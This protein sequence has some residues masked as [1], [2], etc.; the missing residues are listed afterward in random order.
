MEACSLPFA[1]LIQNQYY[2]NATINNNNSLTLYAT[3]NIMGCG[4][5]LLFQD[6]YVSAYTRR[7]T[8]MLH[9][10]RARVYF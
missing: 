5:L 10:C 1:T 7:Q 2:P 9:Y 8:L 4:F 3:H 6:L